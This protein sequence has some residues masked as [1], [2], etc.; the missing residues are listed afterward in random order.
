MNRL[1]DHLIVISFDCLSSLDFP[2]IKNLPH[3]QELLERGSYCANVESIYPTVTYPCHATI[4][5]GN[6]PK[7]HGVV[8][9]TF[10][11]P[12]RVSPDWHWHRRHIQG[13]TLFD[14]ARKAGM[15]TGALLWPVTAKADID[16][17]MPEI[18]A[19]RPWQHQIPVS[20][21]N[22]SFFYQL[23]MNRRFGHIRKGLNQ[24]QLDD[25]VLESALHTI[26]TKQPGLLLIHFTD[27]DTQRHYHGFSSEE[28]MDALKR[29]DHRL[30][31]ILTA[32]RES[33]TAEHTTIVA[34]GDHSAL[35]ETTGVQLNVLFREQGWISVS[36][37]GKVTSW[38]VYCHSCDGSAYIYIRNKNDQNL[39]SKVHEFLLQLAKEERNGIEQVLTADEAGALGADP[40]CSFMLEARPGYYFKEILEGDFLHRVTKEDVRDKRYTYACHGYSP[41]KENYSTFFAAA[42]KG[43]RPHQE[44]PYMRL[45]DEGPTFARLLGLDLGDTDG[46]VIEGL[47]KG[48]GE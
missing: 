47:L 20:L 44:I 37:K 8:N 2:V 5:T 3:F 24:P 9:N 29:H 43:I 31:R 38:Q 36:P 6:Y 32:V 18:F 30:G 10:L 28:A 17:H 34:L 39:Q 46:S 21:M 42:G 14:E 16:Y 11:Q 45:I 1:T 23:E 19:N 4:V 48:E 41:K 33:G 22:G 40:R 12:G 27:L 15:K 7:R 13:T 26:K 35:D 25:F